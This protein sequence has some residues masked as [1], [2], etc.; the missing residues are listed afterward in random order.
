MQD[1][2]CTALRLLLLYRLRLLLLYRL[3]LL[4]L[5]R[6][7]MFLCE[8]LLHGSTVPGSAAVTPLSSAAC[9]ESPAASSTESCSRPSSL[10]LCIWPKTQDETFCTFSMKYKE[11]GRK[12]KSS[13][14]TEDPPEQAGGLGWKR[15]DEISPYLTLYFRNSFGKLDFVGVRQLGVNTGRLTPLP[16]FFVLVLETRRHV[17]CLSCLSLSG[18]SVGLIFSSFL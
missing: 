16:T 2:N 11:C 13:I 5:Y 6:L 15:M 10:L 8:V 14:W 18:G 12:V 9:P 17:H 1:I 4:L 7:H 3:R